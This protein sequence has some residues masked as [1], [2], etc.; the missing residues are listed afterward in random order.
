VLSWFEESDY[1]DHLRGLSERLLRYGLREGVDFSY[2]FRQTRTQAEVDAVLASRRNSSDIIYSTNTSPA[3]FVIASGS[4]LRHV[5][6][7]YSDPL[8]DK[9]IEA[10]RR[11]GRRA[12]GIVE[13]A[14]AHH[15]RLEILQRVV[16]KAKRIAVVLETSSKGDDVRAAANRFAQAH[17]GIA[18]SEV[19]VARGESVA[20]MGRKFRTARIDAAYVPLG[21]E[22]AEMSGD[23]FE[24][25]GR[26]RIPAAGDRLIDSM[27][28]AVVAMEVDRRPHLD[29]LASQL[30]MI[31]RGASPSDIPVHFPR[32]L[33]LMVNLDAARALGLQLPRSVVRQAD[34]ILSDGKF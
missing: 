19:L 5:F 32:R 20:D 9:W 22:M 26:E 10:Y 29:S 15:K 2:D 24:A 27:Q 6:V 11:P 30:A 21:G 8:A 14:L 16:P 4:K 3:S 13:L 12:T 25:L 33:M 23:V 7:T 28:G 17:A 1:R 18:I 31:L 34:L